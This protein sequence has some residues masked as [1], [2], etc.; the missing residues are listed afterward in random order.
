MSV[1]RYMAIAALIWQSASISDCTSSRV[2]NAPV[3]NRTVPFGNVPST[4]WI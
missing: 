3:L 2:V 1:A 4:R